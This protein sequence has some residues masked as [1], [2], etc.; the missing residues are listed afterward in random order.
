MAFG[1]KFFVFTKVQS[2]QYNTCLLRVSQF[3]DG[4]LMGKLPGKLVANE[5]LV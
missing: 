3:L 1:L 4:W 5:L 2:L